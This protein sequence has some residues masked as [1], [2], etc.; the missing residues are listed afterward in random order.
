MSLTQHSLSCLFLTA[1]CSF[2]KYPMPFPHGSFRDPHTGVWHKR[3]KIIKMHFETIPSVKLETQLF[4]LP[5]SV[6]LTGSALVL[7][8]LTFK[9]HPHYIAVL[10][11]GLCACFWW[12]LA[13]GPSW[14]C[15]GLF[16]LPSCLQW[17]NELF[18]SLT[19]RG[20]RSLG[21]FPVPGGLAAVQ[22]LLGVWGN[23]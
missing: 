6:V 11:C 15:L 2:R 7:S 10:Q 3:K 5:I 18:Q 16:P 20:G 14:G 17:A 21:L 8:C 23:C 19:G 12:A 1:F 4:A 22:E 9:I 13:L